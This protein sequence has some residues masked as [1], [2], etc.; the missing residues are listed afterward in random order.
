M[1]GVVT[2]PENLDPVDI[3]YLKARAV[4]PEVAAERGYYTSR[5]KAE[6]VLLGISRGILDAMDDGSA[7]VIP[8][9]KVGR[10]A[11][12][13][14]IR[15]H[16][17][18]P[19]AEVRKFV[20]PARKGNVLDAHPRT[21]ELLGNPSV[22]L[23]V[24]E[25][26]VKADALVGVGAAAVALAGV[27]SWVGTNGSGGKGALADWWD[28]ALNGRTVYLA[29]DSDALT[30][31]E[32]HAALKELT[33]YLGNKGA[34][35]R[36]VRL[37]SL[38]GGGS[39]GVD[40]YIAAGHN[41]DALL[42]LASDEPPAAPDSEDT[43][44]A[45]P[46]PV[47]EKF[48]QGALAVA[49][50]LLLSELQRF[51]WF[52]SPHLAVAVAL[53]V[54]ATY[55][56]DQLAAA[57]YLSITSPAPASGKTTLLLV[58]G[59]TS[60]QPWLAIAPSPAS[61]FRILHNEH[62]T[63]L[64]DEVDSSLVGEGRGDFAAILNAGTSPHMTVPRVT[65]P[66]ASGADSYTEFSPFGMKALSGIRVD[67]VLLPATQSRT[68]TIG[69]HRVP[70]SAEVAPFIE[71]R[72]R[73]G[74]MAGLRESVGA[75]LMEATENLDLEMVNVERPEEMDKSRPWDRWKPLLQVA[76]AASPEWYAKGVDAAL[77]L[78]GV[79]DERYDIGLQALA[80]IRAVFDA[81]GAGY[82]YGDDLISELQ[83]L[84]G[85]EWAEA[86]QYISSLQAKRTRLGKLLGSFG[87]KAKKV[88]PKSDNR[89]GYERGQFVAAW[90]QYLPPERPDPDP[91]R[92]SAVADEHPISASKGGD[93]GDIGAPQ[94][95]SADFNGGDRGPVTT[96]AD[97][98]EAPANKGSHRGLHPKTPES[99]LQ[100]QQQTV[101]API[102][103]LPGG[104]A[105][106]FVTGEDIAKIDPSAG[107]L[108]LDIETNGAWHFGDN[109]ELRLIQ[110]GTPGEAWVLD[111]G[112]PQARDLMLGLIDADTTFV[113]WRS[114]YDI[115]IVARW[116]GIAA[117]RI[118]FID[119]AE[120]AV[121]ELGQA[122]VRSGLKGVSTELL[123]VDFARPEAELVA[124][125]DSNG[126]KWER[127]KGRSKPAQLD[128]WA[129]GDKCGWALV[130]LDDPTYLCY[131][132]TDA[133]ATARVFDLIDHDAGPAEPERK[134]AQLLTSA[135]V[136]G[137][138]IATHDAREVAAA[139]TAAATQSKKRFS[140]RWGVN[141]WADGQV[142]EALAS[143]DFPLDRMPLTTK[144]QVPSIKDKHL[145]PYRDEYPMV[146]ELLVARAAKKAKHKPAE[147]VAFTAPDGRVHPQIVS[148]L[149]R[150]FRMS[151][152]RPNLQNVTKALRG[153]FV[154]DA[155]HLFGAVDY[156]QIEL[157]VA[158]A[159]S[160]EHRMV[161]AFT[162]GA[163]VHQETADALGIDRADA[164]AVNFGILYGMGATGLALRLGITVDEA[165]AVIERHAETYP[166]L[167]VW[168]RWIGET[169]EEAGEIVTPFGRRIPI[170]RDD[171][172][173][174]KGYV[175]I[176]YAVQSSAR[177][178]FAE[179]LARIHDR[180][181]GDYFVLP[182][183]DE[184]LITAPEGEIATAMEKVQEAMVG[185][186]VWN[187]GTRGS[188][189]VPITADLSGPGDTWA[190]VYET[191][192]E[193]DA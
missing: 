91:P 29:F 99:P 66:K 120:T 38:D 169:T 173:Q 138:R 139:T 43:P 85:A 55:L 23:F 122:L 79:R 105:A 15:P 53:W 93:P 74:D 83:T 45:R 95:I 127:T 32:V 186:G 46:E 108:A 134:V 27:W 119:L 152:S 132:A 115:P 135:A 179:G 36:I 35:V 22:P 13:H 103:G 130:P 117:E 98:P 28:I 70:R 7:L 164:K 145:E 87:I 144:G 178:V 73:N 71:T 56:Q 171:E 84:E 34:E 63:L 192:K 39:Q 9:I 20:A 50:G 136:R 8:R 89:R 157:R 161:S 154:P 146:G 133:I 153:L 137:I 17:W 90:A 69:L 94:G 109:I 131:A 176:N 37:P 14:Q 18:K 167:W 75:A 159:I 123:G 82:I 21:A 25:G 30:K 67:D 151:S 180:G 19:D 54:G 97:G 112:S 156:S 68:I 128:K 3:A 190:A 62:R 10:I 129:A 58:L 59:G 116:L 114:S 183:H 51:V 31:V 182:V 4:L 52:P 165:S 5:T 110:L 188:A 16:H 72:G 118:K 2:W 42:A 187:P 148:Q 184:V 177:D 44:R 126:W 40:D 96:V 101:S 106:V 81:S 170:P 11:H 113:V 124:L 33:H 104:A 86:W 65:D 175:G 163:D 80:D 24:T 102:E 61:M 162:Q 174:V 140:E 158:A 77:R 141:P 149:A 111:A 125:F 185:E 142:R 76:H 6:L 60:F 172:G 193:T 57:P 150:T 107:V 166:R 160:G 92:G 12:D 191:G 64:W 88:G 121:P 143:F 1:A 41:L 155:G 49:L 78:E 181:L 147:L 100:P 48:D 26:T 168:K 47:M 189:V